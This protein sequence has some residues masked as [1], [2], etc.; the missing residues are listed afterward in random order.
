MHITFITSVQAN[1]QHTLESETNSISLLFLHFTSK[2]VIR[3]ICECPEWRKLKSTNHLLKSVD[4]ANFVTKIK[5]E[6]I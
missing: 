3:Y 6:R 1:I 5:M 2:Y 4:V